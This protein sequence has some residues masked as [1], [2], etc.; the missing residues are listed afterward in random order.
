MRLERLP[1]APGIA[2]VY[3]T[4]S[5]LPLNTSAVVPPPPLFTIVDSLGNNLATM[6]LNGVTCYLIQY[7]TGY[8]MS[9]GGQ[10]IFS[11][12]AQVQEC[13]ITAPRMTHFTI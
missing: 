7:Q 11:L 5:S 12:R 3:F 2:K 9:L 13:T 8:T 1:A 4:D 6:N 10:V